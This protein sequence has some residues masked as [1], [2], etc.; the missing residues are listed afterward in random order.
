L[1]FRQNLRFSV[2]RQAGQAHDQVMKTHRIV[3]GALVPSILVGQLVIDKKFCEPNC[4]WLD[5]PHV[6]HEAGST[7]AI[8]SLVSPSAFQTTSS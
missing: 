5:Q 7:S 3:V 4:E 8:N 1:G 2:D 6:P